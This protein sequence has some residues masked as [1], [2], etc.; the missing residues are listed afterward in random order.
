MSY[1]IIMLLYTD[2]QNTKGLLPVGLIPH[3]SG[4]GLRR[5]GYMQD[6]SSATAITG[7]TRGYEVGFDL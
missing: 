4:L 5:M 1:S 2:E 7:C 6:P 3:K